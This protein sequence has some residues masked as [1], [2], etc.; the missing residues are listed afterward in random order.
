MKTISIIVL[1]ILLMAGVAWG[2]MDDGY[3]Y[4]PTVAQWLLKSDKGHSWFLE[5]FCNGGYA[6]K[7]VWWKDKCRW[8]IKKSDEIGFWEGCFENEWITQRHETKEQVMKI[9]PKRKVGK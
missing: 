4:P 1:S 9:W 5:R 6:I 7:H 3:C 2:H 8:V